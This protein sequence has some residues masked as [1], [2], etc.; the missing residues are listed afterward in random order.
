MRRATSLVVLSL[1]AAC[2]TSSCATGPA[3]VDE[4]VRVR[5]LVHA[6]EGMGADDDPRAVLHLRLAQQQLAAAKELIENQEPSRA[7]ALLKRAA[8]DAELAMALTHLT[9]ARAEAAQVHADVVSL[10][11]AGDSP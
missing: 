9:S 4:L 3:P 7:R 8:A 2:V 11:G 6:A 10:L 5:G 1:L